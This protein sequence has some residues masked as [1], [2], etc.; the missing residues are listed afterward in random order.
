MYIGRSHLGLAVEYDRQ[1]CAEKTGGFCGWTVYVLVNLGLT[2]VV[3]QVIL[4]HRK[5]IKG[6]MER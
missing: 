1:Q 5:H 2:S 6:Y 3:L 4:L